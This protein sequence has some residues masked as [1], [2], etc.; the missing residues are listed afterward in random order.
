MTVWEVRAVLE[1][2]LA[3]WYTFISTAEL[4]GAKMAGIFVGFPLCIHITD[5]EAVLK[6]P[7][8]FIRQNGE[9]WTA[10]IGMRFDGASI[11]SWAWTITRES[12]FSGQ[13]FYPAIIHDAGCKGI[14]T[15]D[16]VL[17]PEAGLRDGLVHKVFY[18]GLRSRGMNLLKAKLFYRAVWASGMLKGGQSPHTPWEEE[19]SGR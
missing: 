6:A 10:P 19:L 4:L 11:P 12:P 15:V 8:S 3:L 18:E 14:V 1:L 9:V 2:V 16:G 7:F 13:T 5:R 17:R